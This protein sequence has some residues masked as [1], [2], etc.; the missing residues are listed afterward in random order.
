MYFLT[1][2]L[3][4]YHR[5]VELRVACRR[6]GGG[7]ASPDFVVKCRCKKTS[8]LAWGEEKSWRANLQMLLNLPH[9][10]NICRVFEAWEDSAAYYVVMERIRGSDLQEILGTMPDRRLPIDDAKSVIRQVL[11]AV[12]E[13]HS[14]NFI[15]KDLKLEN[16]MVEPAAVSSI[17]GHSLIGTVK[18]IDFDTVQEW[19]P[20]CPRARYVL[21][22]DQYISPE[23]YEGRFSPASDIFAVGVIAYRLLSGHVPFSTTIF[24]D[25]PGENWVGS[26]KMKSIKQKLENA[27]I[28]WN[29][30][31]FSDDRGAMLFVS[32]MLAMADNARPSAKELLNDPWLGAARSPAPS[33]VSSHSK[34]TSSHSPMLPPASLSPNALQRN[35]SAASVG[36]VSPSGRGAFASL[37]S[38]KSPVSRSPFHTPAEG[39]GHR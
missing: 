34:A 10:P 6:M 11:N 7:S 33:R 8:F 15:H 22:T 5:G 9:S 25:K 35:T 37:M 19:T 32:R 28:Q 2:S 3:P 12:S 4:S 21:G 38:D 31:G 30:A 16:V 24:N 29:Y 39:F 13:L 26:P 14:R 23:A 1:E 36:S 18:L 20:V 27:R 17:F